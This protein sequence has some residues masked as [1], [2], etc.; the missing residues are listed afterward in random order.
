VKLLFDQNISHR[1][2]E[3]LS[4]VYPGCSHVRS[5]GIER[6]E[7]EA[8]WAFARNQGFTI[9]S[10]DSDFHQRSFLY[11]PPPK[12][13]WLKVGN[14]STESIEQLLRRSAPDLR[15]FGDDADHAFLIL[16]TND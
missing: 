2:V 16:S 10:K 11:G 13:I 15:K 4:D 8:V 7:D 9:V 1:L 14:C 12:V 3:S 6:A 5:A